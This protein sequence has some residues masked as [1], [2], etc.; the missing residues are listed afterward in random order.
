MSKII[1]F[2]GPFID[3]GIADKIRASVIAVA[4]CPSVSTRSIVPV[5]K[6]GRINVSDLKRKFKI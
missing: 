1:N 2:V 4:T 3:S 6:Y 5:G